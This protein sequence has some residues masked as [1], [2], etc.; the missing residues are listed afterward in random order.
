MIP[1]LA[2]VGV[3]LI[4][5]SFAAALRR[6][7]RVGR[8]LGVGRRPQTLARARELG[9]IDEA[10]TPAEA[11]RQA[12]FLLLAA[13]VN[14]LGAILAE[15]APA[16]REDAVV[17]DAGST[18][19]DVVAAAR[20]ALGA[21]IG[22]FVPG[23]P[24]AGSDATGP[25][26]ADAGLYR[27]RNVI[28]TPLAENGEARV[29]RVAQA[30]QACGAQVREMPAG[31]HD[32]VF[33]S[34]SHLPHWLSAL[35]VAQVAASPDA[36]L[37]LQLAGTGFRDFTRIAAGSP[38]VW[39][40]IFLSNRTA[41]QAELAELRAVMERAERALADGDGDALQA[42]L[43]AACRARRDWS[44]SCPPDGRPGDRA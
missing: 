2:V 13:P 36:A 10:A 28:L 12:D 9:L 8:V 34:V 44:A 23:H 11:A 40:D 39:R 37:R 7:G 24:I 38:E 17:T 35:Y 20:A 14:S 31:Q 4:G 29:L 22:Q 3:G 32:A 18:K 15:L 26:S 30:W 16:L 41:L 25:E 5:G 21:R 33:A 19:Q 43:E 1:V 6:A 42:L 27:G